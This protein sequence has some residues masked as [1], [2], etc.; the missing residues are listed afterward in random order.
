M[1]RQVE[2]IYIKMSKLIVARREELGMTQA[3]LAKKVGI[4]R[5]YLATMETGRQRI[6][7]HHLLKFEKVLRLPLMIKFVRQIMHQVVL[8]NLKG[9]PDD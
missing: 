2:P 1:S 3:Q 6:Y 4:S 9:C 8:K 5:A 7:L